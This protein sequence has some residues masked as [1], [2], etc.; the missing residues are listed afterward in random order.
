MR[1]LIFALILVTALLVTADAQ[2]EL[3]VPFGIKGGV[4]W[5]T[6]DWGSLATPD[7]NTNYHGWQIGAFVEFDFD[8][9]ISIELDALYSMRGTKIV[10]DRDEASFQ[11][12]YFDFP[13]LAKYTIELEYSRP[14]FVLGPSFNLLNSAEAVSGSDTENIKNDLETMEIGLVAGFGLHMKS[15]LLEGRY[16]MGM[17]DVSKTGG[18]TSSFWSANLG[19]TF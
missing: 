4:N 12:G 18:I 10:Q 1:P 6:W 7:G 2:A 19:L 14:Y 17:T 15:V 13:L 5:A 8:F 11:T 16:H 9:F 3:K